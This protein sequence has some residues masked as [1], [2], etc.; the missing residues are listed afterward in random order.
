MLVY[1]N[2]LLNQSMLKCARTLS[3]ITKITNI[4]AKTFVQRARNASI[5]R[6][7]FFEKYESAAPVTTPSP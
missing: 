5:E 2:L 6:A 3:A 4:A 1:Y 7:L